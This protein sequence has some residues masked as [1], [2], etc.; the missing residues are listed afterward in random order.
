MEK[1]HLDLKVATNYLIQLFYQT[2]RMYSC[3]RI[4]IGKILA[5]ISF[6]YARQ[7]IILFDESVF[8]YDNS[9]S[10]I[11]GLAM[12]VDRDVYLSYEYFDIKEISNIPAKVDFLKQRE[13]EVFVPEKY[14]KNDGIHDDVKEC[15]K[16]VF[17]C[18]GGYSSQLI[19]Y[20]M[21][22]LVCLPGVVDIDGSVD[23]EKI[24]KLPD[25]VVKNMKHNKLINYVFN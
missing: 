7:G 10:V 19:G 24:Y 17:K 1:K 2:N 21:N 5:I 20:F 23:L 13:F 18:F 22:D 11:N 3:T 25:F 9:G 16:E 14:K 4:K 12:L 6:K 15:I 8:K